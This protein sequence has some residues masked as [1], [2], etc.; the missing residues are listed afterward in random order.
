MLVMSDLLLEICS[1][2]NINSACNC[3][4]KKRDS[5]GADGMFLS[6]LPNYA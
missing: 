5:C 2:E 4:L 1:E 3:L 6:E